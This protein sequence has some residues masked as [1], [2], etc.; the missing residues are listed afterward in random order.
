MSACC[1]RSSTK[2]WGNKAT[3]GCRL[4][5]QFY[6]R[7]AAAAL[8]EPRVLEARDERVLLEELRDR[9][10]Q[11]AGA[12]P[13][14]DAHLAHVREHGLVQETAG[15]RQGFFHCTAHDVQLRE[16]SRARLQVDADAGPGG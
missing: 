2:R 6:D 12:V 10:A 7:D 13:V 15:S 9:A 16:R 1:L 4:I 3:S 5:L 8:F 11:L 14:D